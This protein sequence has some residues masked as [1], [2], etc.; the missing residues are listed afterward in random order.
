M[1]GMRMTAA[2]SG[3]CLLPMLL[4]GCIVVA[5]GAVGAAAY[6]AISHHEN[7]ARMDVPHDLSRVFT[8]ARDALRELG[9][10]VEDAGQPGPTEGTLKAGD[11]KVV[12]ERHVGNSTRVRV[13]VGTF[14]TDDNTRRANLI[15]E[16]IKR[17]LG[18]SE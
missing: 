15:V 14:Q 10:L 12:V 5:A 9:F 8:A 13:M 17:R 4:S 6:G 7:E 2:R 11:A 18:D 3:L 1:T 16:S